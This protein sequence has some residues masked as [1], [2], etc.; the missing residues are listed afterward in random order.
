VHIDGW[1][2]IELHERNRWKGLLSYPPRLGFLHYAVEHWLQHAVEAE[3]ETQS[4]NNSIINELSWTQFDLWRRLFQIH[5]PK[6]GRKIPL[7]RLAVAL[8]AG[9]DRYA[10]EELQALPA[11][12]C[13]LNQPGHP[14]FDLNYLLFATAKCGNVELVK[15]LLHKGA[16]LRPDEDYGFELLGF[17]GRQRS[18][19]PFPVLP[20]LGMSPTLGPLNPFMNNRDPPI[21]TLRHWGL[22]SFCRAV[23]FNHDEL[24][25]FFLDC[26]ITLSM[27]L[28]LPMTRLWLDNGGIYQME[29][30]AG[31]AGTGSSVRR[32]RTSVIGGRRI[33]QGEFSDPLRALEPANTD[34]WTRQ[35]YDSV[36]AYQNQDPKTPLW[37][38]LSTAKYDAFTHAVERGSNAVLSVL[39]DVAKKKRLTEELNSALITASQLGSPRSVR[40]L[41]EGGAD[42]SWSRVGTNCLE[43]GS[44]C[45]ALIP[46]IQRGHFEIVSLLLQARADSNFSGSSVS[47]RD[48]GR[49]IDVATQRLVAYPHNRAYQ[50]II[51]QMLQY[52]GQLKTDI[53]QKAEY[54]PILPIL[55]D[56]LE[57][58]TANE[59]ILISIR[60]L[61]LTLPPVQPLMRKFSFEYDELCA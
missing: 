53:L 61:A 37:T 1:N 24:V 27:K 22:A 11:S 8:E 6:Q 49:P 17:F 47:C 52:G 57:L 33:T 32:S 25:K 5:N 43:V 40:T 16:A 7:M 18:P 48:H 50:T 15:L 58:T 14:P 19:T 26:G 34:E 20:H 36:E 21:C 3:Q 9:L 46:A 41:I 56:A 4:G 38:I 2:Y 12:S 59:A 31:D 55:V 44:A 60:E 30:L 23:H 45:C 28:P 39:I 13:F 35:I 51:R 54:Q 10:L 29:V 42:A